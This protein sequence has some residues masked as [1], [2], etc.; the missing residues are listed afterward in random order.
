[1]QP[2]EHRKRTLLF[3]ILGSFFLCNAIL[4]EFIG[5]K[6]FSLENTI[7][8]EP[9]GLNI[10]GFELNMDLTA[11]VLPWPIVFV[12][13]DIINEYYGKKGVRTFTYIASALIA[14]AFV[15]IYG[16]MELVPAGWWVN[17]DLGNGETLNMQLAFSKIFGQGLYIIVGSLT[18]F[19][20]GQFADVLTFHFLK[21]R[22]GDRLL[23]LRATGSTLVSQVIDSF[24]VLYIAFYIGSDWTLKQVFAV[25]IN[26]YIY[27]F[28]VAIALTPL[29]YLVHNWVDNYLGK[30]LSEKMRKEAQ[31]G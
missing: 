7:G 31:E 24:V 1:M 23:W 22:T 18:A 21:K 5:V 8:I 27:K 9:F 15:I 16:V 4:A 29:L 25:G 12:M 14:Y 26:N 3:L 13:T 11:G 10:L 19:L 17:K 6:I 20:I 30:E 28:I 2:E